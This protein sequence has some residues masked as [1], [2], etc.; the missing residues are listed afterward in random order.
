MLP[1]DSYRELISLALAALSFQSNVSIYD[2]VQSFRLIQN[3]YAIIE[4]LEAIS[5][6]LGP[7]A[8]YTRNQPLLTK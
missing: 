4:E 7:L 1:Q 5:G 6:V 2:I 8:Y 3:V